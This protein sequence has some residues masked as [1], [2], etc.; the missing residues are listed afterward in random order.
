[1]N[2]WLFDQ[3]RKADPAHKICLITINTS[4][5]NPINPLVI[6]NTDS[7]IFMIGAGSEPSMK[8]PRFFVHLY[9]TNGKDNA[10]KIRRTA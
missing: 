3:T 5:P 9:A 6:I 10:L 7:E 4:N 1:M 8:T 2:W